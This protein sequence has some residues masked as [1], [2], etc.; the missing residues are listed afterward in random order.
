MNTKDPIVEAARL[1]AIKL[2]CRTEGHRWIEV[3]SY[4]DLPWRRAMCSRGCGFYRYELWRGS[5][6]TTD[7]VAELLASNGGTITSIE[8]VSEA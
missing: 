5:S 8:I 4:S 2:I 7:M 3:G 6:V 1:G